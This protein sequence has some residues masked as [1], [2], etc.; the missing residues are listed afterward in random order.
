MTLNDLKPNHSCIVEKL[1]CCEDIK[2][3]LLD[4]GLIPGTKVIYVRK[5]PSGDPTSFW[6]RGTNI[7]IRKED[8]KNI[9]I[10]KVKEERL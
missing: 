5:S 2:R 1:L 3:R 4:L 9:C 8:C 7:A 6:I 10:T